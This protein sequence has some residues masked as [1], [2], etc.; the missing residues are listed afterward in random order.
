MHMYVT[1]PPSRPRS[2]KFYRT[3]VAIR[4]TFEHCSYKTVA[5]RCFD[6]IHAVIA[7]VKE[8]THFRYDTSS[9][10]MRTVV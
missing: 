5:N 2:Q 3:F 10:Q 8:P 9:D 7:T 4:R 1:V 6:A